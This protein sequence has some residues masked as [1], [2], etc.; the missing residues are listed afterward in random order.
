MIKKGIE[1]LGLT[2]QRH[3]KFLKER[4]NEQL[5]QVQSI[6]PDGMDSHHQWSTTDRLTS[7]QQ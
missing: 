1:I 4:K 2:L 7:S 5:L 3:N 6:G